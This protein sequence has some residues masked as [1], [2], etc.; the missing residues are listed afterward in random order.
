MRIGIII[1]RIGDIDGV[2]L[3][4]EKWI[5]SLKYI[6][7]EIYILSGRFKRSV[8]GK[9]KETSL[10][11]LSFFSPEC[12]W[13]QKRAFFYP[14]ET[15][16]ILLEHLDVTSNHLA[17]EI[18]KWLLHN[19]IDIILSENASALPCHLSMGMA[20][21]KVVERTGIPIVSHDHDFYWERG[22]RYKTPHDQVRKIIEET[23][24]LQLKN[25]RHAVINTEAKKKLKKDF[26]IDAT[27]VPNV[28]NFNIPYGMKDEYNA[29][30]LKDMGFEDDVIPLFQITRIVERKGI[31]IAID[32]VDRLDEDRVRLIITGSNADD[33]RLGY[34]RYI[35]TMIQKRKLQDKIHFGHRRIA[36]FRFNGSNGGHKIYSL[37]DAYACAAAC[38]YFST[39][40]GFGNAFLEA[41]LA[42]RP[43]FV[44]NYKPVFWPDIGSKGFKTVVLEDSE[45]TDEKMQEIKRI[46][47][48]EKLQREIGEHNF[49]LGKKYFSYEVLTELLLDL[50]KF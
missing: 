34:Y 43:I 2:A 13:E 23:F 45:L 10:L 5:E 41:V 12:E 40:E 33:E 18:F 32:L 44:N 39:Y 36:P 11:P 9:E 29:T 17:L 27:V 3:E 26:N 35:L 6:G 20:I 37:S 38:T 7:H 4:T 1:G 30:L 50:F 47:H 22:D 24:P 15:P 49:Q 16:D 25:V 8:V 46:I 21:K 31:E 28:M 48:S 14:D 19:K 42:R